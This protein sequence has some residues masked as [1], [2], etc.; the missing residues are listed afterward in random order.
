MLGFLFIKL[1]IFI[2]VLFL[3]DLVKEYNKINGF[4]PAQF[5][6]NDGRPGR[7]WVSNFMQRNQ[8]S[9]KKAE[10]I[11]SARISN[12]SNPFII[13]DFFDQ[14]EKVTYFLSFLGASHS[15]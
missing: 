9:L 11:S 5:R 13:Y 2:C 7:T 14:L 15:Y 6:Q 10:M 1:R 4:D 8:L 3:Q 12:T